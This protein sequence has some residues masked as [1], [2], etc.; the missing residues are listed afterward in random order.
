MTIIYFIFLKNV[1]DQTWKVF[2]TKFGP[3]WKDPKSSYQVRQIIALFLQI[4]CSNF[5]LKLSKV[6]ELQKLSSKSNLQGLGRVWKKKEFPETIQGS[7]NL[8][9]ALSW[10]FLSLNYPFATWIRMKICSLT[11]IPSPYDDIFL[12]VTE[13]QFIVLSY[14]LSGPTDIYL[15]EFSYYIR[16]TKCKICLKLTI[17]IP[18]QCQWYCSCVFIVIFEHIWHVILVFLLLTLNR[19]MTNGIRTT[20]HK[21]KVKAILSNSK[22]IYAFES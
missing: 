1:V 16:R 6:F 15:F 5:K 18:E 8:F 14:S 4:S 17:E 2:N 3:K 13:R 19:Q 22:F 9:E 7:T 21:H 12:T 20:K 10:N 11:N